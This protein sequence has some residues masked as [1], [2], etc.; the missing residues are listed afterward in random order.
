MKKTL[1]L[2]LV[3]LLSVCLFACGS[4]KIDDSGNI[5]YASSV[6]SQTIA[7]LGLTDEAEIYAS[8]ATMKNSMA[9][10]DDILSGK[11]GELMDY[12][13]LSMMN[14]YCVYFSNELYHE[15]FGLFRMT[16]AEEASAMKDYVDSRMTRL[17]RNA[18]NYPSVDTSI[19]D[20]Y[21]VGTD[22]KW[23]WYAATKDN[24]AF[25]KIL[26]DTLYK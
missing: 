6:V 14:E 22:G 18:V 23:V 4:K 2:M 13:E 24:A 11:F 20:S 15:E 5:A 9:F 12:P 16:S 19:I 8:D 17:K 7:K 3:L 21:I 25:E 26:K 10:D 1:S